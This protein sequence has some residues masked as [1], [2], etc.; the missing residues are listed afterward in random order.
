[1]VA[2]RSQSV[3]MAEYVGNSQ[4]NQHNQHNQHD[5]HN[6]H[7]QHNQQNQ[8]NGNEVNNIPQ[9]PTME[10]LYQMIQQLQDQNMKLLGP[11]AAMNLENSKRENE[12]SSR[13]NNDDPTGDK[14]E[15][16]THNIRGREETNQM[17]T[18]KGLPIYAGPFLEFIMSMALRRISIC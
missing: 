5:Q 9:P 11:M 4:C 8:H 18:T 2:T 10:G 13:Q 16:N 17:T 14:E 6:Q 12:A 15:N 1:M 7:N 3:N